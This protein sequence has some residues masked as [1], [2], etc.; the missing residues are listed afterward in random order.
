VSPRLQLD[1]LPTAYTG[2]KGDTTLRAVLNEQNWKGPAKLEWSWISGEEA[3][4]DQLGWH[5]LRRQIANCVQAG[6]IAR[7]W[8]WFHVFLWWQYQHPKATST[9]RTSIHYL[10]GGLMRQRR[11]LIMDGVGLAKFKEVSNGALRHSAG[12]ANGL[13]NAR[14]LMQGVKD[15]AEIKVGPDFFC[16]DKIGHFLDSLCRARGTQFPQDQTTEDERTAFRRLADQW[17]LCIHFSR[18]QRHCAVNARRALWTSTDDMIT[19]MEA[20]SSWPGHTEK[21]T[22]P[23]DDIGFVPANWIRGFDVVGDEN[24]ARIEV[25]APMLRWL[26]ADRKSPDSSEGMLPGPGGSLRRR[27]LSIHAGEDYA[28]PLS[29]MRHIDETVLFCK[30]DDGDRIGHAL[31]LGI[32]PGLWCERQ[33]DMLLCASEH[34]D[35]LVWAWSYARDISALYPRRKETMRAIALARVVVPLFAKRIE[36]VAQH[37]SWAKGEPEAQDRAQILHAAWKYR[38]NCP[39]QLDN[40]EPGGVLDQ[41]ITVAVPGLE[42]L[43]QA[44]AARAREGSRGVRNMT[45]EG[46]YLQRNAQ[47]LDSVAAEVTVMLRPQ[48]FGNPYYDSKLKL[49]LD[50]DSED[51]LQFMHVLQD[52]LLE[53]YRA[54]KLAIETNPTS[55]LSIARLASY[56]EHPIFRWAP[57]DRALLTPG[58]KHNLYGLREG[59]MAVTINTDD[60]GIMPTTLRTEFLLMSA[61]GKAHSTSTASIKWLDQ[62]RI[63]GNTLFQQNHVSIWT[64]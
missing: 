13:Q 4:S 29:G 54:K 24:E 9:L 16:P 12:A 10:Q 61:A 39:F 44:K 20:T 41:K 11:Q 8:L 55:N 58:A 32:D 64:P 23:A 14:T 51:E 49:F 42:S 36:A 5:F 26:R 45:A 28:H 31:A 53:G 7:A 60:P 2:R 62:I 63:H 22:Y 37:V 33:G 18:N 38:E 35:N 57:P 43:L 52:Y 3:N 1:R 25:Y 21:L 48:G 34:L 6:D 30:M 17:H 46:V 19:K 56:G 15:C 40:F 27:F 59:P 50:H 47:N